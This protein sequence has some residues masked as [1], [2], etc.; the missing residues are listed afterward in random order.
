MLELLL[1]PSSLLFV[2]KLVIL[3]RHLKA[4]G[5][6]VI[7]SGRQHLQQKHAFYILYPTSEITV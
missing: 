3:K 6:P 4:P 2:T 7:M 5:I 1:L